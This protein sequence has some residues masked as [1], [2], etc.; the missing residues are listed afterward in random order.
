MAVTLNAS[1]SAGLVQTADTSGNLS[2]QS[3]GTTKIAITSTGAAI[4]G[5]NT[6]DSAAAGYVGEYVSSAVTAT[7]YGAT[8]VW[9]DL[10]SISLT[11][12][13][14]DVTALLGLSENSSVSWT[15]YLGSISD[16]SD[17]VSTS[18]T[19]NV[20][21]S[22]NSATLLAVNVYLPAPVV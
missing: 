1:L 13:D 20:I 21:G 9:G 10:T 18:V 11:A 7:N 3:G 16:V 8:G 19:N 17:T 12:G 4:A 5:T 15:Y 14:W 2:L 6:N 22:V